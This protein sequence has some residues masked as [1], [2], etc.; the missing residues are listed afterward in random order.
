MRKTMAP[1]LAAV[2]AAGLL[3]GC[4]DK[5]E[6][7]AAYEAYLT[8]H[9]ATVQ[10]Q[11]EAPPLVKIELDD[12][13]R[14]KTLVVNQQQQILEP[15]QIKN[16]E[17]LEFWG[18]MA[19][20]GLP[21]VGNIGS[22]WI[23]SHYNYKSQDAMWASLGDSLGGGI[24]VGGDA[25][26]SGSGNRVNLTANNGSSIGSTFAAPLAGSDSPYSGGGTT[27]DT[28]YQQSPIGSDLQGSNLPTSSDMS[29]GD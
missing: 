6:R 19:S 1:C 18:R 7:R 5:Q 25:I 10:A 8:A 29:R 21:V 27:L 22:S 28:G 20:V 26:I 2:M 24:Q 13:G 4:S 11:K 14:L 16:D 15:Q 17:A 9:K 3:A 12:I 23:N